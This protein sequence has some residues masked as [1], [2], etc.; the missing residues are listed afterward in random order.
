MWQFEHSLALPF[1]GIGRK[2]TLSS[3]VATV[4]LS[5][6]AGIL[7]AALEPHHLLRI[8]IA[9]QEFHYL[10]EFCS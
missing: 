6:F 4:E 5:K 1:F 10:H 3:P 9:Q 2:L 7:I 8:E